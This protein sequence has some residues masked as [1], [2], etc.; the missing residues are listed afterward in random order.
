MNIV[1]FPYNWADRWSDFYKALYKYQAEG[2]NTNDD[3]PDALTGVVERFKR[4]QGVRIL[5]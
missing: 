2:K 3:A 4:K 1:Y 5:K